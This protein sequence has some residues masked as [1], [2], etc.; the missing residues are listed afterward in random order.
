MDGVE[1]IIKNL[2]GA[3]ESGVDYYY[4]KGVPL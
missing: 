4:S 1:K 2:Q 3:E